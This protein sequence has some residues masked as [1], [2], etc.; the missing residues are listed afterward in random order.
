M[1]VLSR[2]KKVKFEE[3]TKKLSALLATHLG[4]AEVAEQPCR[5]Q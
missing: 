3:E 1:T 4:S 5:E 2:E